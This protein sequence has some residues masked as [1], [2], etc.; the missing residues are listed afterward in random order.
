M[1][2]IVSMVVVVAFVAVGGGIGVWYLGEV[3]K[4]TDIRAF[5]QPLPTTDRRDSIS[6]ATK[7]P[8]PADIAS[9]V[10]DL[11]VASDPPPDLSSSS[12]G[13]SNPTTKIRP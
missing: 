6:D 9:D 2:Y 13:P 1:R 4:A 8:N 5:A 11:S 3:D 12:P 10:V 7:A